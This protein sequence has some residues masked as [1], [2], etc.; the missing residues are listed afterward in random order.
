[1][2]NQPLRFITFL[3]SNMYPVY[4]FITTYLGQ[5][6]NCRTRLS[7]G[8]SFNQFEAG[9]AEVGFICG[10]PYV[11][12]TRHSQ[13][14]V[15]LLAA[16]LLQG[17]RYQ[18]RPV[19]FSDIIVRR[20]SPFLTFADL[21][22]CRWAYNETGSHSGYNVVRYRL[23][24]LGQTRGYFGRV[25]ETGAHQ[26]SIQ[27]VYDGKV[28]AAAID[29]QILAVELRNRP[30]LAA[31]LRVIET[32]GPSP[33]LPVVAS[34]RLPAQLRASLR[35]AL[36]AMGGDPAARKWLARGFIEGFAPVTDADYEPI[37]AMLAAAEV[38]NFMTI[39]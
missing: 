15:E 9:Q 19:Y 16:P 33:G 29:S 13:P 21:R 1:M 37:R 36:L 35:A 38:A 20:D 11:Q 6:L 4:Q 27:M 28:D 12:L 2:F 18:G 8:T 22:G 31:Q 7:V 34:C 26:H 10:L 3:G 24:Q 14:V 32:L 25:V 39:S 30:A 23:L 17:E 5:R